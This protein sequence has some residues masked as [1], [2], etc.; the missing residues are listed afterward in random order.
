MAESISGDYDGIILG[1]G[2]NSLILQAYLCRAGL[3]VLCIERR[4]RTGGG[5]ET[6]ENPKFPGFRH[7]THSF[8][9]RAVNLMPWYKDLELESQGAVYLEPELNV[10]MLLKNGETLEWWTDFEKMVDSFAQFSP[11]DAL[12]LRRWRENFLP[13]VEKILIPEAQG[14]PLSFERRKK[15]LERCP[16]GRLLLDV[17]KLSPLG[18]VLNEFEHPVI[19]AGL[20]FF[21]GLREVDLKCPGFGH[22]IAS[23]L[24]S[25][26]KAQ[27]CVGGSAMLARALELVVKKSGG[28]I[29]LQSV[30]KRLLVENGRVVGVETDSGEQFRAR[31]F[32]ASSLNPQQ[33][34]LE[35]LDEDYLPQKWRD[36][37]AAFKFNLLSPIFSLN[38]NLHESPQYWAIEQKGIKNPLMVILG[39]E[40]V[41]QYL[42]IIQH[43][44]VGTIPKTLMWG[45][46]PTIFDSSQAPDGKHTAFMW[47]KLPYNLEGGAAN[48][49]R[50]KDNHGRKMLDVWSEYA[51]NIKD[52]MIDS[53]VSSPLD[54]E[55]IFPNMKFG[56]LSVGAFTHGQIG[57]NRPFLGAGHYRGYL[58][59]LY[60]CGSSCHPGGN[61]TG[62]PGYNSAQV[63]LQDLG[64][65]TDWAPVSIEKQLEQL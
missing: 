22:H 41:D 1:A 39:L 51:P 62:L 64:Y 53:F 63:I 16:E 65:K 35:L 28:E 30:P 18:F 24:A 17:S 46:C 56:D 13:I 5:L 4:D 20:L 61:I 43:H 38:L 45:S 33:T 32:V 59:G 19:Q 34:F 3:R 9:H 21:N 2:H 8:Y 52:V 7:N 49:D 29:R 31:Y 14:P 60:L 40:N 48:W 58:P 6:I 37:A 50:I 11:K 54:V 42:K 44:K 23:L 15:L 47:E 12:T 55:R 36:R 25:A 57:Y 27:I 26:G 10:A